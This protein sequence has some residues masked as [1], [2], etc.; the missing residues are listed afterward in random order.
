MKEGD[1]KDTRLAIWF[2]SA[3][4][5]GLGLLFAG[6]WFVYR[7][8]EGVLFLLIFGLVFIVTGFIRPRRCVDDH[9]KL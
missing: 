6:L 3:L 1:T 5:W 8:D 2:S 7:K 4:R 9:C